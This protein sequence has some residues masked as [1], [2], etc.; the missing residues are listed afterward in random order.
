MQDLKMSP[1]KDQTSHAGARREPYKPPTVT[2][3]PL[4]IEERLLACQK[5]PALTCNGQSKFG[6]TPN[7]S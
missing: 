5:T 1:V 2:V 4:K 7:A 6:N 3:I